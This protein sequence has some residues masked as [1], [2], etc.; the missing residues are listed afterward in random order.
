[1]PYLLREIQSESSANM[2]FND[3]MNQLLVS[4]VVLQITV[5]Q[6]KSCKLLSV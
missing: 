4:V 2:V 1:M 3:R 6:S 5:S